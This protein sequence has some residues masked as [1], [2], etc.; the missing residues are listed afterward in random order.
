M[1]EKKPA[2]KRTRKKDIAVAEHPEHTLVPDMVSIEELLKRITIELVMTRVRHRALLKTLRE[3]TFSWEAY[4]ES[5]ETVEESDAVVLYQA[6]TMSWDYFRANNAQWIESDFARYGFKRKGA[7]K[8][9]QEDAP[10]GDSAE[11]ETPR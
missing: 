9:S 4:T 10:P 2:P 5:V 6:L 3:G 8:G 11:D 1:P 7:S